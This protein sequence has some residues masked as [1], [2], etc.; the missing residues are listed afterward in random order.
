M[1]TPVWNPSCPPRIQLERWMTGGILMG[2]RVFSDGYTKKNCS[3]HP[4][5]RPEQQDSSQEPSLSSKD[6]MPEVEDRWHLDGLNDI[7]WRRHQQRKVVPG[8]HRDVLNSNTYLRN[9][10]C[11]PRLQWPWW[12]KGR[13]WWGGGH[14]PCGGLASDWKGKKFGGVKPAARST[15]AHL[16]VIISN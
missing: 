8:I 16:W 2:S 11:P 15:Q 1:Q 12:L 6:L 4:C 9:Q 10:F 13:L 7:F 14:S 5:G 3:W